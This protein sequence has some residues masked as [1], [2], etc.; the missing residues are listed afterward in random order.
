RAFARDRERVLVVD[1]RIAHG[2]GDGAGTEILERDG[3]DTTGA[4]A[5]LVMDTQSRERRR[6]LH[7]EILTGAA[8]TSISG[9]PPRAIR[10]GRWVSQARACAADRSP[11]P[12][13]SAR[14]TGSRYPS[15]RDA[16]RRPQLAV[17]AAPGP[18]A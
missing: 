3:L 15:P 18:G 13:G 7:R 1:G 17:R 14:R 5:A 10:A 8:L 16:C 6:W 2:H 12:A 11:W 4:L 9:K